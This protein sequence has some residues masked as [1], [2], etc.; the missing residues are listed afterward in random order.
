MA[1]IEK[2]RQRWAIL[3]EQRGSASP[4][5]RNTA[6]PYNGYATPT[7]GARSKPKMAGRYEKTPE[8]ESDRMYGMT[9][10][11]YMLWQENGMVD[12]GDHVVVV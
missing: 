2:Q 11:A 1:E 3:R 12:G 4:P 6:P 7:T 10:K 9:R 5:L 8:E